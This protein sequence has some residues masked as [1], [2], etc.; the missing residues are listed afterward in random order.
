MSSLATVEAPHAVIH[1]TAQ[2]AYWRNA[3][4]DEPCGGRWQ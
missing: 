1:P 4:K 3:S 2:D